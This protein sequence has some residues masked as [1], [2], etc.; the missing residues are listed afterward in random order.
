VEVEQRPAQDRHHT[1]QD[2]VGLEIHLAH[3]H[4]KEIPVVKDQQRDL[5]RVAAAVEDHRQSVEISRV[6]LIQRPQVDQVEPEQA[7]RSP[8]PHWHI[9]AVAAV[10]HTISP[11]Q[12]VQALAVPEKRLEDLRQ[13]TA[14]PI[15]AVAAVRDMR[16]REPMAVQAL[17]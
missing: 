3:H 15:V 17:W 4:R 6:H 8:A 5:V 13:L 1:A 16:A 7:I 11:E 14:Q 9:L 10:E 2:Q 12:A